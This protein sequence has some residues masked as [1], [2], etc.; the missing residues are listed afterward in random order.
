MKTISKLFLLALSIPLTAFA[1]ESQADYK[2]FL[3]SLNNCQS[4]AEHCLNF[5][6]PEKTLLLNDIRH[7]MSEG[8]ELLNTLLSSFEREDQ[9]IEQLKV[10]TSRAP[11]NKEKV[12]QD[13]LQDLTRQLNGYRSSLKRL[14]IV[15]HEALIQN[16]E[17]LYSRLEIAEQM[18]EKALQT[19]LTLTNNEV[20]SLIYKI[21]AEF[22]KRDVTRIHYA[23]GQ[24][25]V[26]TKEKMAA[27]QT[28]LDRQG[29]LL[30]IKSGII[31]KSCRQFYD[32]SWE[33]SN[34]A[35]ESIMG[36]GNDRM[37]SLSCKRPLSD[38]IKKIQPR[39]E[40]DL[41]KRSVTLKYNYREY[42]CYYG[43]LRRTCFSR[44]GPA[45]TE[46]AE[47]VTRVTGVRPRE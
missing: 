13:F 27:V 4:R 20:R 14:Q 18:E 15:N 25:A 5:V 29:S 31:S 36:K 9:K 34:D 26:P 1:D 30:S 2:A 41:Q 24:N 33:Y 47:A 19:H 10:M 8:E 46:A 39:V 6:L 35:L 32:F 21:S 45:Y 43:F 17:E 37:L 38:R 42:K 3:Q 12:Y 23:L 11:K 44:T 16:L 7:R 22:E 28:I 40:E